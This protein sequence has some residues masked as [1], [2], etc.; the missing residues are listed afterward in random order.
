[1]PEPDVARIAVLRANA[2]GDYIFALPALDALRSAYPDAEIALPVL[3][4]LREPVPGEAVGDAAGFLDAMRAERFD[5]ALQLHGASTAGPK[6]RTCPA[7]A[8]LHLGRAAGRC[9]AERGGGGRA[10]TC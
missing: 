5:L 4:G 6:A 9:R 1:M 10:Q 7:R 3:P 8:V 2:I